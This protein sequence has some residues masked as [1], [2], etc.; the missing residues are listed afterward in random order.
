[1]CELGGQ[2]APALTE[3]TSFNPQPVCA[4]CEPLYL[5]GFKQQIPIPSCDLEGVAIRYAVGTD[6]AIREGL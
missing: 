6:L 4:D 1:M 2:T 5:R 3:F